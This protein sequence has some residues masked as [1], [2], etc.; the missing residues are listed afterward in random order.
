MLGASDGTGH[1]KSV[2]VPAFAPGG[3]ASESGCCGVGAGVAAGAAAT[4]ALG[5][6]EG[7]FSALSD[8]PREAQISAPAKAK[9][10]SDFIGLSM[11]LLNYSPCIKLSGP[12]FAGTGREGVSFTE[13]TVADFKFSGSRIRQSP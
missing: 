8:T 3:Y 10:A 2:A 13:T 12:E 6:G 4:A 11:I 1:C 5:E 7:V 9:R